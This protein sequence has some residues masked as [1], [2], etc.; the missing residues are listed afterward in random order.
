LD[1]YTLYNSALVCRAWHNIIEDKVIADVIGNISKVTFRQLKALIRYRRALIGSK[2]IATFKMIISDRFLAKVA[3]N[4]LD[5]NEIISWILDNRQLAIYCFY[6]SISHFKYI[7]AFIGRYKGQNIPI[8]N[9]KLI[10]SRLLIEQLIFEGHIDCYNALVD[11]FGPPSLALIK[12]VI[13]DRVVAMY[14]QNIA[15]IAIRARPSRLLA[16]LLIKHGRFCPELD[17]YCRY[18]YATKGHIIKPQVRLNL[19]EPMVYQYRRIMFLLE[20]NPGQLRAHGLLSRSIAVGFSL[21]NAN[22]WKIV[23]LMNIIGALIAIKR[24]PSEHIK[25]Y[26][27]LILIDLTLICR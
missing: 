21:I 18:C 11:A 8:W 24:A 9:L 10:E 22:I 4:C 12:D 6:Y 5:D 16:N 17:A 3:S 20:A 1:H 13:D 25:I 26:I 27:G 23:P 15:K 14:Y 2:L 7:G 19:M